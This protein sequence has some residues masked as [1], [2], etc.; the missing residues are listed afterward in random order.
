MYIYIMVYPTHP[1]SPWCFPGSIP[2][3]AHLAMAWK[4]PRSPAALAA[5]PA[6]QAALQVGAVAGVVHEVDVELVD[7][8]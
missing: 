4:T 1:P 2:H 7:G 6:L 8:S 5:D 3:R